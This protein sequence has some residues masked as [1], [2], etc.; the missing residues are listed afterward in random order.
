[1]ETEITTRGRA[2]ANRQYVLATVRERGVRFIRLWFVDV[3]GMLKSFAVPVTELESAFDE[4]VSLDGSALEGFARLAERDVNAHPDASTFQ[5]LPWR[6]GAAVARMMC[7]IRLPDGQPFAGDSR[8]ALRRTLCQAAEL[9]LTLAVGTEIEF[10][11]FADEDDLSRPPQPLDRGAYFDLTPLDDGSDFRRATIEYLEQMG[12]PVKASHHEVAPSQHEIRLAHTDALAMADAV[13]TFRL[14]VKEVAREQGV[15]AT[16]MPKPLEH[17]SGSGMHVHLSL[18]EGERNVFFDPQGQAPLSGTGQAF[19]AGVLAHAPELSAVTNQWVN[20]YKRLA[21]GFEA[22]G[23]VDWTRTGA[24]GLVRIPSARP[25]RPSAARIELR[26]PDSAANPYL[27][28]A[29]VLAAGLRGIERGYQL[30]AETVGDLTAPTAPRLPEDLR[31]AV[32]VFQDSELVRDTL[33]D[34]L[35]EWYVR[36]KRAEWDDYRRTVTAFEWRRY[37]RSL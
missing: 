6:P 12:I 29:L 2:D 15:Y 5:V 13:T 36:N 28:F 35:V 22:P 24:A 8:H 16:F 7:D 21:D 19:L 9:G 32:N 34:R 31:E 27:C 3:L 20:S 26:S 23:R 25:E 17:E 18:F 33:G 37:L 14:A 10:F 30:G 1:M 4:G 11:L